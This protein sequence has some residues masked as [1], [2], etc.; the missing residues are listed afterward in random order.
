MLADGEGIEFRWSALP[1]ALY[2]LQIA[3]D[4]R[5]ERIVLAAPGLKAEGARIRTLPPGQ[6]W[7]RV[8]GTS[9]SQGQQSQVESAARP[10]LVEGAR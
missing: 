8:R 4:A 3:D 1:G 9:W 10:L 6:Y 7:W 5:F 2:E